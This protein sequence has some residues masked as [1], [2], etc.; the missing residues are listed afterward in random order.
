[1]YLS[2]VLFKKPKSRSFGPYIVKTI[3][4]HGTIEIENPNNDSAF[5]VNGQR[6]KPFFDSF[7]P[8]VD[9]TSLKEP[10]YL[11]WSRLPWEE[12]CTSVFAFFCSLTIGYS[13]VS[14]QAAFIL[15]FLD[16]L[17]WL[18]LF[19]IFIFYVISFAWLVL[20]LITF[21]TMLSLSWGSGFA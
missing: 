1:M 6:S 15:P 14:L 4:Q 18:S 12:C 8:E 10:V 13:D 19:H 3:F 20:W 7:F 11:D 2:F 21:R 17:Y 9:T 5:K 16:T